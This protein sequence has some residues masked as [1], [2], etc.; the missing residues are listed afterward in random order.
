ME[1]N[2]C[3][4]ALKTTIRVQ[5]VIDQ[6]QPKNVEPLN[7]LLRLTT[8]DERCKGEIKS[9]IAIAKSGFQQKEHFYQQNR[10]KFKELSY[11]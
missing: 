7:Y 9:R 11:S 4:E 8:N 6:K 5:I 10:L 2:K 1:E 3:Y